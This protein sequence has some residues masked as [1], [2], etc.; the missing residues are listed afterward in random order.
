MAAGLRKDAELLERELK[1]GKHAAE[2]AE[3]EAEAAAAQA[4]VVAPALFGEA[5]VGKRVRVQWEGDT[6]EEGDEIPEW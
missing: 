1:A 2:A 5:L 3:A 4:D 6:D